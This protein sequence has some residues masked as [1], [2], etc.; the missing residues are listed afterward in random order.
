LYD[1]AT[2]SSAPHLNVEC[3]YAAKGETVL[4]QEENET[5]TQVGP[6]T[7]MGN[8]LRRYWTPACLSSEL[9]SDGSPLE[10]RLLGEDLVAFR[11]TN[12]KPALF[13]RNCPHR[14]A[15]VFYGRNE[16]CGLRCVYHGW[17]FDVEGNCVD[18]PSEP[19]PFEDR[20]KIPSYPVHESGGLV[21]TYMGPKE[22]MT[23][24]R[25]FGTESLKDSE[26]RASKMHTEC[27]W[28]QA[29]EG[30]L[31]SAHISFLHQFFGVKDIPDDGSDKPGYPSNVSSWKFWAH[32]R[33]P[34]FD[35]SDEWY[36]YRYAA[37]RTTPEE[38]THVR[39]N[40]YV[41]PWGTAVAT[42]PFTN[43]LGMF[44][45]SDDYNTWRYS[46]NT[47]P[48]SN[49]QN[50]GG[51]P[52]FSVA[53][54]VGGQSQTADGRPARLSGI[55]P[56]DYNA[57][58][59]YQIDRDN[60]KSETYSGIANFVSQDLAVT[61]SMGPIYNRQKEH[62]GTTDV[63]IIRMRS[64]LIDAAKALAEGKEPPAVAGDLDYREIRGAEKILDEGEDWR[65]LGTNADP[66]V[67][68]AFLALSEP[69]S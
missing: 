14:G 1:R 53:P 62:L 42:V 68:E 23:P 51:A 56:R 20:I 66:V 36:G 33:S 5:L 16:E 67:K 44:V 11:D 55:T 60:Q 30:N 65:A 32:D 31:D 50:L 6:G 28:V 58:N 43:T 18:M 25:N 49:P 69:D 63:A 40:A 47:Q 54:Y 3:S 46:I 22:T 52:L 34:R 39:I 57:A 35:M 19:R 17:K 48:Y 9:E 26:I 2:S 37:M 59:H 29:M 61:E 41:I 38:H 45:P 4:S 24:F 21:W 7:L 12:G 64:I 10:V 13:D 8:L 15:S 27:N